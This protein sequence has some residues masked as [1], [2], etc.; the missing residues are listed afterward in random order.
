MIC[1]LL[2]RT[3]VAPV[4]AGVSAVAPTQVGVSAV[5]PA[6]A[7]V[8]AVAP[9]QAGVSAVAPAQDVQWNSR[10][11]PL[12]GEAASSVLGPYFVGLMGWSCVRGAALRTR[13]NG[14]GRV[15]TRSQHA[16]MHAGGIAQCAVCCK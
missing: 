7:G 11:W 15:S 5:A 3:A 6:Q 10:R 2:I 16:R 8:S 14:P 1:D 4:Q 9:A 12:A 13:D